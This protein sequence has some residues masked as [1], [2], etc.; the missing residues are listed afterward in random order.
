MKVNGRA[1]YLDTSAF[2]KLIV[3]E[4][5]TPALVRFLA[6]WP[7]RVSSAL[8][9][10]EAVRAIKRAGY[11]SELGRTRRL[12]AD[13][14][15]IRMDDLL[16]DRAGELEPI[17]V[18]SLDAIHVATALAVGDE[19]GV[20]VTYDERLAEAGRKAGLA[21]EAPGSSVSA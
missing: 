19:L 8:L 2:V 13:V 11:G 4:P 1:V 6:R 10:T 15:L 3:A 5:D 18:R 21:V 9:R 20:F 17:E 14:Q 12:L 7:Y 16:L